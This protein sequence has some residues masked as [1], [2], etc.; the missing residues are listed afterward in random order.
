MRAAQAHTESP[1]LAGL[2][3]RRQRAVLAAARAPAQQHPARHAVLAG[4]R[5]EDEAPA[6]IERLRQAGDVPMEHAIDAFQ[7]TA[8]FVRQPQ[9]CPPCRPGHSG[10]H[11]DRHRQHDAYHPR[12]SWKACSPPRQRKS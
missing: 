12:R 2:W 3:H 9:L 11:P 1:A 7:I 4:I 8:Q 6:L 5:L 10:R